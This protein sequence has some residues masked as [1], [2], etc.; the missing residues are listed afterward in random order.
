M[1][2]CAAALGIS[3]TYSYRDAQ[4]SSQTQR[5]PIQQGTV[6]DGRQHRI[7]GKGGTYYRTTYSI[8]VDGAGTTTL[9][10]YGEYASSL[11]GSVL[12]IKV[13]PEDA[14]YAEL[15]DQPMDRGVSPALGLVL[16]TGALVTTVALL[17]VAGR[18]LRRKTLRA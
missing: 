16:T 12:S 8:R 15:P 1:L 2:L 7:D 18:Q 14:R 17:L 13:D 9:H 10:V 3:T 4:R 6:V 11:I 5:A